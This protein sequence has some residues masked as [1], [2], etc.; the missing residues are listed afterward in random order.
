MY[1]YQ[2]AGSHLNSDQEVDTVDVGVEPINN[3]NN[4]NNNN[5]NNNFQVY[6]FNKLRGSY[7]GKSYIGT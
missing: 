1:D 5:N 7:I 6:K 2:Y 3:Q 4:N